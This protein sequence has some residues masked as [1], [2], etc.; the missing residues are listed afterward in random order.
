LCCM[1]DF[2]SS[3][4]SSSMDHEEDYY[5]D[6]CDAPDQEGEGA[7]EIP[8]FWQQGQAS[9]SIMWQQHVAV[10]MLPVHLRLYLQ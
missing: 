5:Q 7:E 8:S 2:S 10:E 6:V 9:A 1:Q 3:S 4:S